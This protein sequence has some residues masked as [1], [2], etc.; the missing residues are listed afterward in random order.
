[1][2][3]SEHDKEPHQSANQCPEKQLEI[4]VNQC[5]DERLKAHSSYTWKASLK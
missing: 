1:M 2:P 3:H 4:R 5:R